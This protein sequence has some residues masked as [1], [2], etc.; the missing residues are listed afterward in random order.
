MTTRNATEMLLTN[1]I[2]NT[3]CV[4]K[5]KQKNK[6]DIQSETQI[7]NNA[8]LLFLNGRYF[9]NLCIFY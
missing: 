9:E 5:N 3:K 7:I 4:N 2:I 8:R 1:F 6:A